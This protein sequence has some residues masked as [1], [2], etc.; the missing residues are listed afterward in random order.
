M[1]I[2]NTIKK[3]AYWLLPPGVE[4]L[5]KNQFLILKRFKHEIYN[6]F[7]FSK[8]K[9]FYNIHEGKRC[10]ILA[11]GP[12]V[13]RQDLKPL[14]DEICIG[15]AFFALHSDVKIINPQYHIEAANHSPFDF[16]AVK[17]VFDSYKHYSDNTIF[18]LGYTPY[19]YSLMNYIKGNP[20]I[21]RDTF[22][23]I[24]YSAAQTIDE[25]NYKNPSVWDISKSPF[26]AR[27]V[28][29]SAIQIAAYMGFKT[30]YLLGCDHDYLQDLTRITD[31]HFYKDSESGVSDVGHLSAFSTEWWF[32]QYYCRWKEYRLMKKYLEEQ[33]CKIFNATEGGMLDVFPKI[34]LREALKGNY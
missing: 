23:H 7:C 33:D 31:H 29:Y 9:Q 32:H 15:V 21:N 22:Y 16:N 26:A 8:L 19:Q 30:I 28:V 25:F 20:E 2:K 5:T 12:S 13:N 24:N 27:T 18:F 10:F 34:T 14:K 11:T 6:N 17:K 3:I 4:R 1:N